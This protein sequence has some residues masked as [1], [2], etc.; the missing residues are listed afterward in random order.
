MSFVS[1]EFAVLLVVVLTL[2]FLVKAPLPR[3]LVLLAA[4]CVFYA[5][6]DWRFLGL[7]AFVTLLD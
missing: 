6:W 5:W 7:L 1:V 4:S 3:K 2:L